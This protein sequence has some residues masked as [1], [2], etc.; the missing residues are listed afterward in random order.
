MF[1]RKGD[2]KVLHLKEVRVKDLPQTKLFLVI[3]AYKIFKYEW[4][5]IDVNLRTD[6]VRHFTLTKPD[7][8]EYEEVHLSPY[9]KKLLYLLRG[10]NKVYLIVY[11]D[12]TMTE[13]EEKQ[14]LIFAIDD[15]EDGDTTNTIQILL[16]D[17]A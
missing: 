15:I 16:V 14:Y 3:G 6:L 7:T 5:E 9:W 4:N 10:A 2:E 1:F 11:D 12:I 8:T 13:P 17:D